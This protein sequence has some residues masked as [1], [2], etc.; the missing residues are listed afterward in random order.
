MEDNTVIAIGVI[1]TVNCNIVEEKKSLF[2]FMLV[3]LVV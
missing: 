2:S 1:L 3:V